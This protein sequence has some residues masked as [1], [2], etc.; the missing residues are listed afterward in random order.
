[1]NTQNGEVTTKVAD[2]IARITFSHPKSN[3]LPSDLLKKMTNNFAQLG[4]N[5]NVR[6]IILQSSGTGA[7]CAGASFDELES[8][9]SFE[10]GKEFFMGFARLILA[11]IICPKFVIARI[12]GK[13][14]GGGVGLISASDYAIAV[15]NVSVRLSEFALGIGP[16]VVA[17]A[18]ER[19]IGMNALSN[20]TIDT[21]WRDS[22]WGLKKG[23]FSK[24]V[25]SV[26][27]LDSAVTALTKNL[28]AHSLESISLLKRMFWAGTEDWND[29]LEQRAEMS[30]KL[31]LSDFTR[32]A[33]KDFKNRQ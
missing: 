20:M 3:S 1:M 16:F 17:P 23:L 5:D 18:I 19:K 28:A 8:I 24:V 7:F 32:H 15:K 13:A 10:T 29:L 14:V 4:K 33:I 6:V 27:E 12:H 22:E 11:M 31:V 25:D 2:G 26:D 9:D 21:E 30:G